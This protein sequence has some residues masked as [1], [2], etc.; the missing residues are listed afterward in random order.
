MTSIIIINNCTTKFP[1]IIAKDKETYTVDHNCS[2]TLCKGDCSTLTIKLHSGSVINIGLT[3]VQHE[4][5][6]IITSN[7][8]IEIPSK[9]LISEKFNRYMK[10]IKDYEYLNNIECEDCLKFMKRIRI[11]HH[12]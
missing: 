10:H 3:T 11:H 9:Y 2:I 6:F 5:A 4:T 7:K 8:I 1:V 12:C